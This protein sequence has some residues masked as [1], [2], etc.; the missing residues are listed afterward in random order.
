MFSSKHIQ[1]SIKE[2]WELQILLMK[3]PTKSKIALRRKLFRAGY[4]FLLLREKS[5]ENVTKVSKWWS[6]RASNV[7]KR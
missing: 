2:I 4:D 5:G 1:N 3:I 6:D 7:K